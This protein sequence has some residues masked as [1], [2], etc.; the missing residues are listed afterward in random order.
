[1]KAINIATI[2][3]LRVKLPLLSNKNNLCY[4]LTRNKQVY[5]HIKVVVRGL[6]MSL[7]GTC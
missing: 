6:I 7:Q 2:I 3:N 1:M 5:V 4:V